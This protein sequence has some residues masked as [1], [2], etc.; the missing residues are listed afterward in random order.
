MRVNCRKTLEAW[1]A[2]KSLRLADSVWT[3]GDHIYSYATCIV[4]R[5]TDGRVILNR[6]QY[7]VTTT[8]HQKAL[9][10]ALDFAIEVAGLRC[11]CDARDVIDSRDIIARIEE[12]EEEI[13]A[14]E[15]SEENGAEAR[16]DESGEVIED[17]LAD[18]LGAVDR[19]A[20]SVDFDGETYWIR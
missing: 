1:R 13:A 8:T 6:T 5:A 4:A 14:E 18:D 19:N 9:A 12:L 16:L 2:G 10:A 20:P 3:N 17:Q 7:S 15:V 11:G